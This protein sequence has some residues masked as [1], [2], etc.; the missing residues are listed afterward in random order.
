MD[1]KEGN[2][3]QLGAGWRGGSVVKSSDYPSRGPEFNSR[4]PRGGGS[5]PS[6]MESDA[7]LW[8]V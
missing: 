6:G 3:E 5:Q 7:P 2:T 8:C 1:A 4:Q